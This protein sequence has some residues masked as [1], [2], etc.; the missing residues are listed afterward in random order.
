MIGTKIAID[1]S[2]TID[3]NSKRGV[4]FY[5]KNLIK[6]LRSEVE[7]NPDYKNFKID[8]IKNSKQSLSS[9]NLVHYPYFDPF[10]LTL[11]KKTIPRVVTVH[12]LIPRLYQ[13]HY[14]VGLKGE[15]KWLIQKNHLKKSDFIITDSHSSK[16]EIKTITNY[17][18]DHIYP[19]Y[20]SADSS[21]KPIKNKLALE[22]TS[23]KYNLPKKF[24]LYVGDINWNKNIPRLV[25][26]CLSLGYPLVIVGAAATRKNIQKHPWNKDLLWLQSIAKKEKNI[27]LTGFLD[28]QLDLVHIYNLAT[29]YC[30]ASIA[31][32][33]GLPVLEAMAS[34][35]PV[36]YSLKS[37]VAEIADYHGQPFNPQKI[38]SIKRALKTLWGNSQKR[39]LFSKEGLEHASTFS[40]KQVA[41]QTLAVY[42][43]TLLKY[44]K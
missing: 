8:L 22:K 13:K 36:S 34:G 41:L 32:G 9:Y 11:P 31:E 12:D 10:K 29:I 3:G 38:T 30:Q 39:R 14:P 42:K 27:I 1:I 16:Y 4:G 6:F 24:V 17:P 40:W 7:T 23:K 28:N 19:I 20:L 44:E 5:T 25:K 43:L 18:L 21:F 2:P 26:S 15:I 37:S 33:F 35:T